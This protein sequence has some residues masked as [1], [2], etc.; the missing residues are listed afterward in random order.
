MSWNKRRMIGAMIVL[1]VACTSMLVYADEQ[2]S[3][4]TFDMPAKDRKTLDKYL[5]KGVVGKAVVPAGYGRIDDH[6]VLI[7]DTS[8]LVVSDDGDCCG[9]RS[10]LG[11]PGFS[12]CPFMH[13]RR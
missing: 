12:I 7:Q 1:S 8:D 4:P 9:L 3:K 6:G 5:G 13:P 10:L 2:D 11:H